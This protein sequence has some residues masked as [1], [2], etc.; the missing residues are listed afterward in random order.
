MCDTWKSLG[1]ICSRLKTLWR[2]IV[3]GRLGF[4]LYEK[5]SNQMKEMAKTWQDF[6]QIKDF[7]VEYIE[8]QIL[9]LVLKD[10]FTLIMK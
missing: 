2:N 1:R 7:V 10:H 6:I 8:R 3:N 9:H 4:K 5:N